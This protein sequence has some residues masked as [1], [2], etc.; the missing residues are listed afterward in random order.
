MR[1][2][3]TSE[4]V[5]GHP[6]MGDDD[7][8]RDGR[9]EEGAQDRGGKDRARPGT[10]WDVRRHLPSPTGGRGSDRGSGLNKLGCNP[11]SVRISCPARAVCY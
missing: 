6:W 4:R 5:I 9:K 7:E 10:L 3:G 1:R 2:L 11:S 8:A